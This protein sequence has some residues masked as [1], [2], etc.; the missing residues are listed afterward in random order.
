[1]PELLSPTVLASGQATPEDAI[2]QDFEDC[3]KEYQQFDLIV[4]LIQNSLDAIDEA[5]YR[6]VCSIAGLDPHAE[7]T[8][9]L[10]NATV[11]ELLQQDATSYERAA[12][13][14][15]TNVAVWYEEALDTDARREKWWL[16][17]A[18]TF[19]STGPG[20]MSVSQVKER[21]AEFEQAW[22]A[23]AGQLHLGISVSAS[24]AWLEIED[25]GIGIDDALVAFTHG[26]SAKRRRL[27]QVRRYGVRGSH[28]WGLTAVLN[29]ADEMTVMSRVEGASPA[30][31][32]FA[33]YPSFIAGDVA[34][35]VNQRLIDSDPDWLLLSERLRNLDGAT[36]THIRVKVAAPQDDNLFG[37]CLNEER[38]SFDLISNFLRLYTPIG[39]VNDYVANP[40]FHSSRRGDVEVA[41]SVRVA[42]QLFGPR[43]VPFSYLKLDEHRDASGNVQVPC[44]SFKEW[45]DLS[46]S[47]RPSGPS[48]HVLHREKS[49]NAVFLLGFELQAARPV[50]RKIED[51][52]GETLPGYVDVQGAEVRTIPRGI[53]FAF[54]GGMRSEYIARQ[55]TSIWAG[56]RG[57]ILSE[58]ARP[59]LGRKYILDQ[60]TQIPRAAT[61]PE[62]RYENFRKEIVTLTAEPVGITPAGYTW[63]RGQLSKAIDDVLAEQIPSADLAIWCTDGSREARVM[64]LFSELLGRGKFGSFHVLRAHLQDIYDFY[65]LYRWNA[66]DGASANLSAT[67]VQQGYAGND[68]HGFYRYGIGEFKADGEDLL[69]D[70]TPTNDR[71][72]PDTPDLLVCWSF[73]ED[74]VGNQNWNVLPVNPGTQEF[75]L[76][77]HQW[78]QVGAPGAPISRSRP[79]AVIA[80]E[81][82]LH[83]L[84]ATGSLQDAVVGGGSLPGLHM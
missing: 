28:G 39:Q 36:G 5:R 14:G 9:R 34:S 79:L 73:D 3:L 74:A 23:V 10:W 63:K 16:K 46:Q 66:G 12:N 83:E 72:K 7:D 51:S 58:S 32:R 67:L 52:F 55:S 26:F 30:A 6:K 4:E 75:K 81:S 59:T 84:V 31:Y 37:Y 8:V 82:V 25:N 15:M 56:Y 64:L 29:F 33:E 65:F 35:P 77:T 43:Q 70:F 38:L 71:K 27:G 18:D 44:Y 22:S 80:L 2:R 69:R 50:F 49:G 13:G 24:A 54:S 17:L 21:A 48:V 20:S 57:I 78:I 53:Q 76:Q 62:R 42:G 60:R 1:M 41:L 68:A 45:M 19:S 40:A 61:G 11:D 47:S